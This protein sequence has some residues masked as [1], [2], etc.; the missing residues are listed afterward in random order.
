MIYLC[1]HHTH[2]R[3]SFD[4]KHSVLEMARGAQAAGCT[5]ICITD[6]LE[7]EYAP[8]NQPFDPLA[9]RAEVEQAREHTGVHILHGAEIG[10]A[11]DP[12]FARQA[13][14]YVR[15]S[16]PDFIIGS[17]HIVGDQNVFEPPYFLQRSREEAYGAYL[18]A[19]EQ[20]VRTLPE[21]C[22]LGHYDY[23]A[24]SAPYDPRPLR[25]ADAPDC[26]DNILRWLAQNGKGLE[27]NTA[28]WKNDPGWGLDVL[29]RF[30]ELGGEFVTFGSDAHIPEKVGNRFEEARQL[31]LTAGVRY[32][33]RFRALKPEFVPL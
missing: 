2:S 17:I 21:L 28:D 5:E 20:S 22:V 25:Y 30:V 18:S 26:M 29:K 19:I 15:G 4:A 13:W 11:P 31:A 27:I 8:W 6:H 32:T 3:H 16:E 1:D 33:A 7:F 14:E 23:V 24:K 9:Q 10:L 12:A